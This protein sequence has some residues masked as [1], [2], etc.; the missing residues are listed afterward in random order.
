MA[1]YLCLSRFIE[2]Q[3]LFLRLKKCAF[4]TVIFWVPPEVA[5]SLERL[6]FWLTSGD[7]SLGEGL[8]RQ[9]LSDF[10]V[11]HSCVDPL[12]RSG[13]WTCFWARLLNGVC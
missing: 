1:Y 4:S 13:L 7:R 12:W 11:C 8:R 10:D 3:T 9:V 2:F 6:M 5:G